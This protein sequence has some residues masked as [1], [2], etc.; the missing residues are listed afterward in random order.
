MSY[1]AD[2]S[3]KYAVELVKYTRIQGYN[4]LTYLLSSYFVVLFPHSFQLWIEVAL[5]GY[6]TGRQEKSYLIYDRLLKMPN[7][8]ESD[9]KYV[10]DSQQYSA[11]FVED[12]YINYNQNI[13]NEITDR[14]NNFSGDPFM[15]FS[16]TTCKRFDLF[17]KTMN[18]FL[19][20]CLDVDRIQEWICVDDNS[21]EDDREKMRLNYP[22]FKFYFK[23][24]Y[25][26][27]HAQS[28]NIIRNVVRGSYVFHMEDDWKFISKRN[29]ISECLDVMGANGMFKQVLVNKNY[30]ELS[31]DCSIVGGEMRKT[32]NGLRYY[33]HENPVTEQELVAF[34]EKHG[35]GNNCCYWKHY[36]LRPSLLQTSIWKELGTYRCESPHFEMDYA[37]RFSNKGYKSCF[38]EG[39]GSLH[40]GRLTTERLNTDKLNAYDLNETNQFGSGFEIPFTM[41]TFIVNLERRC[42][43]MDTI[44][45]KI[46]KSLSYERF[47]AV[48]GNNVKF[49]EQLRQIFEHNDY[50][51]RRGIVGCALSH[52]S[53]MI[54]LLNDDNNEVYCILED[55]VEFAPNFRKKLS[56]LTKSLSKTDWGMCYLTFHAKRNEDKF[57][58]RERYP[59][60]NHWNTSESLAESYGGT[61]GYLINKKGAERFLNYI[62]K[63]S[64]TNGIDTTLQ[65]ASNSINVF[66]A[67]PF[68]VFTDFA[69]PDNTVDT[70]IQYD[71]NTIEVTPTE[72]DS[73]ID[74]LK[75]C[76]KWDL[77]DIIE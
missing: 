28:M 49:S 76:G 44:K 53:L 50:N 1:L 31:R 32:T 54:K 35:H 52:L 57:T 29:Y 40:I 58:N 21:S 63:H 69:H 61:G 6:Y 51:Y 70:D 37:I 25:E 17:E 2:C 15:S 38:L 62:Q 66:Y 55:D 24:K 33:I 75:K 23:Q 74:R 77:T 46:P 39:I 10:L 27:G 22:F 72:E 5:T 68:L 71:F 60:L 48:D 67:T 4:Y 56:H 7:L 9:I 34:H 64:M 43:R 3:E 14:V 73:S 20:C 36:S 59:S 13:V 16:I 41:N 18:S 42:D 45:K 11:P 30:A 8:S 47:N 12:N 26:K 65:R 19:N